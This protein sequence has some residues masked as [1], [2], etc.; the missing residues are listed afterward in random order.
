MGQMN[1]TL[2]TKYIL[3]LVALVAAVTVMILVAQRAAH[4]RIVHAFELENLERLDSVLSD[5]AREQAVSAAAITADRLLEPLFAEDIT[6]V[7]NI[8]RPLLDR[9]DV[10][11]V[12][13]YGR[14]GKVFHD[15][16][17]KLPSFGDD[18]PADVNFVLNSREMVV[19]SD[20]FDLRV[21]EPIVADGYVFGAVVVTFDARYI[22]AEVTAMRAELA[23]V[24]DA[25]LQELELRLVLV[26]LIALLLAGI[27]AAFL[28]GR[29][30]RPVRELA[31][32]TRSI[33]TGNFSV[34]MASRR[35]DE[36]GE[37]AHAFDDMAKNL[38]DTMVSRSQLELTVAEQTR[39]LR[40]T[41]EALV[42]LEATRRDV[43]NEIGDDLRDPIS[44]IEN[45]IAVALRNQDSA[46]ELRHSM[47]RL[48][49]QVRDV[50]RL[51]EDLRFAARSEQPR[52]VG[53]PAE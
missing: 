27:A 12:M 17:Q 51:I 26:G 15:G 8:I 16:S 35:T 44:A 43:L 33:G 7:G 31:Q 39:E 36:L 40:Q 18:A 38:R 19:E 1:F 4:D 10:R 23:M 9:E 22:G 14:D 5:N 52:R 28:A 41:H 32:V 45:D 47:S 53:R 30:S 37:L 50:R 42:E 3:T 20:Q 48:L 46:M 49:F 11:A 29:M 13:V 25:A 6:G 34:E 24:A 21:I 2:R